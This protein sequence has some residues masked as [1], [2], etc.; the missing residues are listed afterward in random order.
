M[1]ENQITIL[2]GPDRVRKR[3]SVVFHSNDLEGAQ[4]AV[5]SLLDIFAAE[6]QMGHCKNICVKQDGAELEISGDDRGIYLGQDTAGDTKW[7]EIFCTMYPLPACPPNKSGYSFE[8]IDDTHHLLYGEGKTSDSIFFPENAGFM[9]LCALQS[10]SA[11]MNVVVNRNGIS[12]MLHFERGYNIG[13][14]RS[15]PTSQANGTCFQFALDQ[16]V[17]TQTV[18]PA[19]FFWET[20][21][22]FAMLSPGLRC[23]YENT[24]GQTAFFYYSDGI[25][26]YVQK[27][28]SGSSIPVYHKKI[29]EKG[30]ERYDR[31]EYM[32]CVDIAIGYTP[33]A[34]SVRC[35][36]NFRE[37]TCGGT[38]L[39]ELKK[40]I[41]R[42]FHDCYRY[43]RADNTANDFDE[44]IK[45]L[46]IVLATWCSPRCTLWENATRQSIQNKL[47]TDMTHDA[48]AAEFCNY[49][50]RYKREYSN[51]VDAILPD[52]T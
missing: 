16:E 39:D 9:D 4:T 49:L 50:Y 24:S 23:T 36:H 10:V 7:K 8:L 31:A 20:L 48:V 14:M 40:Q 43:H 35:F 26:E 1:K 5:R 12:S 28:Y 19:D 11:H 29:E 13:G 6:A 37:L 44:I 42:A 45:H 21:Q 33:E 47:V 32:A 18:I 25:S 27:K 46:T 3:P 22:A 2:T 17:F 30:R 41:C 38:H 15:E 51:L 34:G 52:R